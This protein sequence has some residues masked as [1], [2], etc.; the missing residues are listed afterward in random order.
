[1]S[2]TDPIEAWVDRMMPYAHVRRRRYYSWWWPV[3]V[4]SVPFPEVSGAWVD[5]N[6]RKGA[7]RALRDVL[8]DWAGLTLAQGDALPEITVTGV[9]PVTCTFTAASVSGKPEP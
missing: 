8:Y 4:A 3:A 9:N 1:M 5:R 2:A 6:T 7:L